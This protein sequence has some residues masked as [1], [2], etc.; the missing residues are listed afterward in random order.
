MNRRTF[1]SGAAAVMAVWPVG[2]RAQESAPRIGYVYTGAKAVVASRVEA[3][4]SG[5]RESGFASPAQIEFVVRATDGDPTRIAPMTE[6]IIASKVNVVIVAGPSAL[7]AARAATRDIPIVALDLESDPLANGIAT[8]LAHPGGNVTGVFMDFPDVTA[9]C[10]QMLG[11][12]GQGLSHAA[13]LWDPGVGSVQLN[14]VKKAAASLKI[15]LDIIEA[16]RP[17]DFENAF[18]TANQRNISAMVILS[19]PL[20]PGN[21]QTLSELSLRYHIAA[22]TLFPD[23][24][25]AGGLLAYG[26]NLLDQYRQLGVMSGKI[27]RGTKAGDLPIERPSKFELVLNLKTAKLLGLS[28]SPGLLLRADEVIE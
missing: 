21:V 3:I 13:I 23:F 14:A 26:P 15:E 2:L 17:A 8:S 27:I 16:A 28:I 25:R 18:A 20:I 1:L 7:S 5:I 4:I 10:L 19:S 9:K 22:I 24:G 6:E 12:I 11:E